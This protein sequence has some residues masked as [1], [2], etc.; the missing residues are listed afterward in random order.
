MADM[1]AIILEQSSCPSHSPITNPKT[2]PGAPS[3]VPHK[4]GRICRSSKREHNAPP[5]KFRL[6]PL[7]VLSAAKDLSSIAAP[8]KP[9][10]NPLNSPHRPVKRELTYPRGA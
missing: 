5:L 10:T 6:S 9:Q 8:A 2:R 3:F 7:V 1:S 4:G